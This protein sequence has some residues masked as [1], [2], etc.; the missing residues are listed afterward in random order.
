MAALFATALGLAPLPAQAQLSCRH[1]LVLAL[2]V[3]GSVDSRE[4]QMQID[5]LAAALDDPD[6][7]R[8]LLAQPQAPVH[9][10]IFEWS[11]PEYQRRLV[12]WTAITGP[13]ML[14]GLIATLRATRRAA[15]P[16]GT[17]IGSALAAGAAL[18]DERSQC[19]K[20]TMD[21]SGDGKHNMG[22]HPDTLKAPLQAR[23]LTVNALVIGTDDPRQGDA[24]QDD[25]AGL[26]SYFRAYVI[27]GPGAFV[28]TALGFRDYESAMV[29]KL[30]RELEGLSLANHVPLEGGG[31]VGPF[32]HRR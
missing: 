8:A 12:P 13:A 30:L 11:A 14:D 3:S 21:I 25:V 29:R 6:V 17:A 10:A 18:L 9:L 20:R 4:Y 31:D 19:W 2:D 28:E 7:R 22:P 1:A 27:T 23:D 15:A 16:P 24:R 32:W 26:S 5:G